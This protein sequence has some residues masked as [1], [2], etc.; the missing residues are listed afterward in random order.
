MANLTH[1]VDV[2]FT[3]PIEQTLIPPA[4]GDIT[5]AQLRIKADLSKS[6]IFFKRLQKLCAKYGYTVGEIQIAKEAHNDTKNNC[7]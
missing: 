2:A 6:K 7:H 5:Q 1:R 4:S 3:I